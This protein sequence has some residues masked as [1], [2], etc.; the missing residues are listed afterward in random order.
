MKLIRLEY[1]ISLVSV[2]ELVTADTF[3]SSSTVEI[4]RQDNVL[5]QKTTEF[6]I[7]SMI[8][9]QPQ[10]DASKNNEVLFGRMTRTTSNK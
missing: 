10:R 5:H 9:F 1:T 2:K 3:V 4:T 6:V 8:V 7:L